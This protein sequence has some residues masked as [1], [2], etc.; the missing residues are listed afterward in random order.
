[1]KKIVALLAGGLLAMSMAQAT[2]VTPPSATFGPVET[3]WTTPLALQ[4]FNNELGTLT[5]VVFNYGGTFT[6]IFKEENLASAPATITIN[7]GGNLVF[8]LPISNTLSFIKSDSRLVA[9]FDGTNGSGGLPGF[10]S[11]PVEVTNIGT[12]TITSNLATFIGLGTF[13]IP[14]RADALSSASSTGNFASQINTTAQAN[15]QVTYTFTEAP[16]QVPEPGS[17][18]LLGLA[19]A[20]LGVMRRKSAQA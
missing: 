11:L 18:A 6:S 8:G 13:G 16:R 1:M 5:S 4:Q 10:V 3:N 9:R 12:S 14:V 19:L 7:T 17:L 20:G 15:I 2:T